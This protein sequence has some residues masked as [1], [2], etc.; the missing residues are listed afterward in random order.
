MSWELRG[1]HGVSFNVFFSNLLA[2]YMA[3]YVFFYRIP[4]HFISWGTQ[5]Y[6]IL[7]LCTDSI[8]GAHLNLLFSHLTG[9]DY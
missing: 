4:S 7:F 6:D 8:E 1:Y 2:S 5:F 9:R 3:T